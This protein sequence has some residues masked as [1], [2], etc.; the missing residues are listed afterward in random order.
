MEKHANIIKTA[1]IVAS[2]ALFVIVLLGVISLRIHKK[3]LTK[4]RESEQKRHTETIESEMQSFEREKSALSGRLRESNLKLRE[5][6]E[7]VRQQ[8]KEI[9]N[10]D[11]AVSLI[12]EPIYKLI[13]AR[14]KEGNFKSKVNCI[15][16]KEYVLDKGQIQE[17]RIAVDHHFNQLTTRLKKTYPEL[18]KTDIDYCCLYLLGLTDA[19][20]AALMQRAYNTVSE[21]SSRLRKIFGSENRISVTLRSIADNNA[22]D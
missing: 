2:V 10:T 3:A 11:R 6:R 9:L 15:Y 16:Y 13:M 12:E 8:E 18:T 1:K 7:Q 14:V 19:D 21:R 4:V 20:V 5:L 22:I 17:L